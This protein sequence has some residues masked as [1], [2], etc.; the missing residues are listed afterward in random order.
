LAVLVQSSSAAGKTTLMDAIL[1][2]MPEEDARRYSALSP[3]ALYYLGEDRL[4]HNILAIAEEE[5]AEEASYALKLLQSDGSLVF[6]SPVKQA[7]GKIYT[8]EIRIDG[9]I[10]LFLTTTK[11][12][13]TDSELENRCI[14]LSV[15]EDAEQ[16]AAIHERQRARDTWDG[17]GVQHEAAA[18]RRLHQNAQRLL[19]PLTVVNPFAPQLTFAT[20]QP[21]LRRDHQK[22]LDLIKTITFLHQF[23]RPR[24]TRT[25]AGKTIE[26]VITTREDIVLANELAHVVLGRSLDDLPPQP[27]RLLGLLYEILKPWSDAAEVSMS[28]CPVSLRQLLPHVPFGVSQ[29]R[30]HLSVLVDREYMVSYRSHAAEP[31]QYRLLGD[32]VPTEGSHVCLGLVDPATICVSDSPLPENS[33]TLPDRCRAVNGSKPDENRTAINGGNSKKPAGINAKDYGDNITGEIIA[34]DIQ[35]AQIFGDIVPKPDA[36][37]AGN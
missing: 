10:M 37:T 21:R 6:A 5:G 20:N 22:Y 7:D 2:L 34:R 13:I 35:R 3:K 23:Q 14:K 27:R 8:E 28:Q 26:A 32:A 36:V 11:S 15:N 30:A 19:Q 25:I 24:E 18:I 29:L 4:Q 9:P 31:L 1:S 17:V 16:T 33:T 12:A